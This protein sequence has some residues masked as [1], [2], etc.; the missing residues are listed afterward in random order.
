MA[1]TNQVTAYLD[2]EM[3][4]QLRLLARRNGVSLSE[5]IKLLIAAETE[6]TDAT[7]AS[8]DAIFRGVQHI[9]IG[10]DALLKFGP[11][12]RALEAAKTARAEKL[13][14]SRHAG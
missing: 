4:Q 14:R 1:K 2:D 8:P 13:G 3:C 10:I 7:R 6:R 11:G 9:A 5:Q 12:D